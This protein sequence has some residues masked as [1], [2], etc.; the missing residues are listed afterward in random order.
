[1]VI[2]GESSIG[3]NA[4]TLAINL[5]QRRMEARMISALLVTMDAA[6]EDSALRT[7]GD[8]KVLVTEIYPAKEEEAVDVL[9][10]AQAASGKCP[11]QAMTDTEVAV[12]TEVAK[13]TRHFHKIGTE[14]YM[15]LEGRMTI[16]VD[17]KD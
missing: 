9:W 1:M 14:M 2:F 17:G 6:R 7:R 4:S 13:Q 10:R 15:L 11:V 12:F 16:E 3:V 8:R 5:N